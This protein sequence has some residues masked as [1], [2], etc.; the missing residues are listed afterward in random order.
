[1][2]TPRYDVKIVEDHEEHETIRGLTYSQKEALI[3]VLSRHK[4]SHRVIEHVHTVL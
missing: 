3:A 4:I 2:S 1:M